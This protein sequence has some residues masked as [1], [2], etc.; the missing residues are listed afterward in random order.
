MMAREIMLLIESLD[1][2]TGVLKS[3]HILNLLQEVEGTFPDDKERMMAT[4][5]TF[6]EMA[7]ERQCVYQVG[8]R[9]GVF[10]RLSD[11]QSPQRLARAERTC[12]ELGITPENVDGVID[13]LMKRFI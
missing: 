10:T 1:G 6:L 13:E 4:L 12:R 11:M 7:P 5:R 8:R 9:I 2:I 3:D